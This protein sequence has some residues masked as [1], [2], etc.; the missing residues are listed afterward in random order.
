MYSL[1]QNFGELKRIFKMSFSKPF[2]N[3]TLQ[4]FSFLIVKLYEAL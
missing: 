4:R 1:T 3:V 2:E